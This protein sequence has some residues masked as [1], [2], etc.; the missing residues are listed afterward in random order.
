MTTDLTVFI[1]LHKYDNDVYELL[2]DAVESTTVQDKEVPIVISCPSASVKKLKKDFQDNSNITI[3]EISENDDT[4]F[5]SQVNT[6]AV[7]CTTKYFSILE[8][9]DAYAKT[10]FSNVDKYLSFYADTDILLPIAELYD[11]PTSNMIGYVN[12][13]VWAASFSN[14]IGH[15]DFE[16]LDVVNEYNLT[17]AIFNTDTFL[18]LCGLKPSI[19]ISFW[20]EFMLRACY[21]EKKAFV[22]PKV[23]YYHMINREDSLSDSYNK[24]IGNEEAQWWMELAKQEYFF[25]EDRKKE[26]DP[27]AVDNKEKIED[28]K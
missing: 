5:C 17:G 26:Y 22:V 15:I 8:Y 28:L 18:E 23:G 16:S 11:Y 27:N 10:W 21:H 4:D 12:E 19:K 3:Y 24:E 13:V 7:K 25:N 20:Q 2:K 1:P 9:D 6:F 14:E